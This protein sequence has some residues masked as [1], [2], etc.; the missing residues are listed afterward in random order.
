[1]LDAV[2]F[3]APSSAP[4]CAALTAAATPAF[5]AGSVRSLVVSENAEDAAAGFAAVMGPA[6]PVL[7]LS[8]ADMAA[9]WPD[10]I[11]ARA[12]TSGALVVEDAQANGGESAAFMRLEEGVLFGLRAVAGVVAGALVFLL[13]SEMRAAA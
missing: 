11:V 13:D 2:A 6:S 8:R 5:E 4:S 1:M 7:V 3:S 12:R 10:Y 9:N